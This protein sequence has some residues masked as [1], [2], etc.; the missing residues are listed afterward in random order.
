MGQQAVLFR[1]PHRIEIRY[2]EDVPAV[3][4]RVAYRGGALSIVSVDATDDST[5]VC[6]LS[7]ETDARLSPTGAGVPSLPEAQDGPEPNGGGPVRATMA[8]ERRIEHLE[9]DRV[10]WALPPARTTGLAVAPDD[11]WPQDS[12]A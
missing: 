8:L 5:V 10:A 7:A 4:D 12:A 11:C 1:F 6:V 2:L 3:G 9:L